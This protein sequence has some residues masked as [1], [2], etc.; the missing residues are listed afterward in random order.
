MKIIYRV[1]IK[2]LY[3]SIKYGRN[4][5]EFVSVVTIRLFGKFIAFFIVHCV[6]E[7]ENTRFK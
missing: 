6:F 3:E 5:I 4:D 1:N 2:K 7:I